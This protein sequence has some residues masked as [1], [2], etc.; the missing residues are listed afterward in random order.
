[1]I[2]VQAG[3]VAL[4]EISFEVNREFQEQVIQLADALD[5]D[6][7]ES[8][9]LYLAAQEEAQEL[10]RNPAILAV[11]AFHQH[12]VYLL[13]C[14]RRICEFALSEELD[15]QYKELF[16]NCV[17]LIAGGSG[18]TGVSGSTFVKKCMMGM[19]DVESW[20]Q[21]IAEQV[22]KNVALNTA[23]DADIDEMLHTQ[24]EMLIRQHEYLA[25]TVT[26]LVK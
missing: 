14:L 15:E 9:R 23:T 13:D 24:Q 16:E 25:L 26:Y 2:D 7:L 1:M 3:K 6:E 5:L 22:Q 18:K 17:K 11:I 20:L 19:S 21:R 12:R 8:T 4:D 10:D